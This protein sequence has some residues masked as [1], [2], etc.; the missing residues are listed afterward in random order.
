MKIKINT[1]DAI[2]ALGGGAVIIFVIGMI[3]LWIAA[4]IGWVL[5][6]IHFVKFIGEPITALEI[7]RGVGI[8]FLPLGGIMGW[9]C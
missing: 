3:S 7:L 5:N 8:I 6:I 4:I 2:V 1:P 9:T